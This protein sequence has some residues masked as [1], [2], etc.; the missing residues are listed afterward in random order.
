MK[1][2]HIRSVNEYLDQVDEYARSILNV[3]MFRDLET[4]DR[5]KYPES[6]LLEWRIGARWFRGQECNWPL[7]PK[8]YRPG[9]DYREQD[10]MLGCR[11]KASLLDR[12]ME[13]TD[14]AAWLFLMQHHGLPTRLLDWTESSAVALY[15][16]VANW[17]SYDDQRNY[18]DFRP[19]VW[20][21]NP[22]ALNWV[23][24]GGTIVP[25]TGIDEAATSAG[26]VDAEFGKMNVYAAF[27]G[28]ERAKPNPIAIAS[29]S[30]HA[31]MQVQRGLFI[32]YG[33]D[34]RSLNEIFKGTDLLRK[35]F[36][37]CF[38][39][40]RKHAPSITRELRE[41]GITRSTLFPD[42]EGLSADL[43]NDFD[44]SLYQAREHFES[45]A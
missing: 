43:A 18:K 11:R 3:E 20:V 40:D 38:Q 41:L 5:V 12:N 33:K 10:M 34:K 30:I 25:G 15:F 1:K 45:F 27:I 9:R 31:R 21:V 36:L 44:K 22:S 4:P 14:Y 23:G 37:K 8:I 13:W 32:A 28:D 6:A 24:S 17:R 16:A 35:G 39:I 7:L 29:M 2:Q 26:H 42:L 19:S